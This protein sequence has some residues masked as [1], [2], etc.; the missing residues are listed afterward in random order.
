MKKRLSDFIHKNP[1]LKLVSLLLASLIWLMVLN[2]SNPEITDHVSVKLNV[3]NEG[4]FAAKNMIYSL[5]TDNIRIGYTVRTADKNRIKSTAFE[6]YVD[7]NDYSV[8]GAVPVY[9]TVSPETDR[10]I[11]DVSINPVVVHVMTEEIQEK[12]F[13]PGLKLKG[14][15]AEGYISGPGSIGPEY[16]IVK[17][18]VS[19]IGKISSVGI[20]VDLMGA[21][22]ELS[23]EGQIV[24][25]DA[26]GNQIQPGKLVSC[27]TPVSYDIP[28]YRI[29]SLPV[30]AS[31][32]GI[33]AAGYMVSRVDVEPE[34]ARVYG[35]EEYLDQTSLISIPA[36]EIN[37]DNF[38]ADVAMSVDL[39]KYIPEGLGLMDTSREVSVVVRIV[40]QPETLP[41][42]RPRESD[43]R[44]GPDQDIETTGE[45]TPE[46]SEG[47][48]VIYHST[49]QPEEEEPTV[50]MEEAT[51][52]EREE[53]GTEEETEEETKESFWAQGSEAEEPAPV[54]RDQPEDEEGGP[55]VPTNAP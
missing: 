13:E 21:S 4:T 7:M 9:L 55:G 53:E 26:N 34:S 16:V 47:G 37:I 10:L 49:A 14:R 31:Y 24:F 22:S 5:N 15:C 32:S 35:A 48:R 45:T 19:D 36:S 28:V 2:I 51:E 30:S 27:D 17:G 52:S 40:K 39:E 46:E 3:T 50:V 8:T 25:Y 38:A 1:G 20:E 41:V 43:R 44:Y 33:P 23:G 29:K 42:I 54:P 6:A 12:R 11:S 18:P